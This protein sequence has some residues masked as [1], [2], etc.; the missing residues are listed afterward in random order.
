LIEGPGQHARFASGDR[1]EAGVQLPLGHALDNPGQLTHR[2][3]YVL[4]NEQGQ[5]PSQQ[6]RDNGSCHDSVSET[7][8]G[9]LDLS[10][11]Q[12]NPGD[13]HC[14]S[15]GL[16]WNG[17]I[18]HVVAHRFAVPGADPRTLGQSL[19]HFWSE[20]VVFH[21]DWLL[22]G[23]AQHDPIGADDGHSG[24]QQFSPPLGQGINGFDGSFPG[25]QR[26][27]GISRQP[28]LSRQLS[29]QVGQMGLMH[30]VREVEG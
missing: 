8:H 30:E 3:G 13:P 19:L 21:R 1:Q 12:R 29:A 10:Q 14:L 2:L 26:F 20:Q 11:R 15:T 27:D 17:D 4:G 23:I 22:V 6:G 16:H 18:H 28:C 25:Q 9:G 5:Q 7:G 24:F